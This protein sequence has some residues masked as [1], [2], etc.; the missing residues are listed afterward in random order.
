MHSC[1][2]HSQLLEDRYFTLVTSK[3]IVPQQHH[4]EELSQEKKQMFS[5]LIS[6]QF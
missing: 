4:K 1:S 5:D 6:L 2:T 3:A